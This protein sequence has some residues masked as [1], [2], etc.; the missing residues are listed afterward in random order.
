MKR[1]HIFVR[2]RV[3]GVFFR[4]YTEKTAKLLNLTG[5]VRNLDDGRVEIVAEGEEQKLDELLKW[6]YKGSPMAKV[7]GVE[8][9]YN[10]PTSAFI[11]FV[12]N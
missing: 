8:Y 3:Q 1:I 4:A 5:F 11:D 12:T 6:S 9:E 10:L 7:T 2:G